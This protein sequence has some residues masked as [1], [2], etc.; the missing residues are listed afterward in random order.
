[1]KSE[2]DIKITV[3]IVTYNRPDFLKQAIQSVLT[4][5]FT[6]FEL[7]ISN[8]YVADKIT[9]EDLGI[10]QDHRIKIINQEVNLGE[11]RNLNYLLEIAQGEW[12]VWL[13]D[14]DLLHPEFLMLSSNAIRK[15]EDQNLVAFYSNYISAS[16]PVGLFPNLLKLNHCKY[17]E[18]SKFL[19]DYSSRKINLVGCY[20]VM[21]TAALRNIGGIPHLGNSFGPY[22]DTLIP[23]LLTEYGN[24]CWIDEALIFFRAHPESMSN[25]SMDLSAFTSAEIDF[26]VELNRICESKLSDVNHEKVIANMV[27]WFAEFEWAVLERNK[28]G[29]VL[30]L[31]GQFIN[32][33]FKGNLPRLSFVSKIKFILF[34][35][36]FVFLRL[37]LKFTRPIRKVMKFVFN[38]RSRNIAPQSR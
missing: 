24:I 38:V 31:L 8:D 5:S 3:G 36:G 11:I 29:N 28:Y 21:L 25:N 13:G 2:I 26:L 6:N 15:S 30:T 9:L 14:D 32:C 23:I 18:P 12:F 19:L 4:Q 37:I 10:D 22:S 7:L 34:L 33:Q 20:G 35:I 1:M 16:N 27:M 17:Y